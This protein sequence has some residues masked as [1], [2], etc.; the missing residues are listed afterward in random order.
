MNDVGGA[1]AGAPPGTKALADLVVAVDCDRTLTGP[2]LMPD[3]D[4]LAAVAA[5]RAAGACCVLVTG[6]TREELTRHAPLAGAFDAYVL[7]GGATW[8][9]W[10]DQARPGNAP[11]ALAAAHRVQEAGIPV[12]QGTASFSCARVD[13]ARVAALAPECAIHANVDRVDVLPPG[14]DKGMGLEAALGRLGRRGAHVVAIGDGEND[15]ALFERAVV[16]LAVA[17]AH[18]TLKAAADEVLTAAGPAGVVEAARRLLQGQWRP[19]GPTGAPEAPSP[20]G[21]PA[22]GPA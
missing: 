9:P 15:V 18:A 6:R 11:L 14:M 12:L 13:L 8:G 5:L 19:A 20:T 7:E 21:G 17:N 3:A 16:G 22:G 4:A 2:D 10:D 1:A